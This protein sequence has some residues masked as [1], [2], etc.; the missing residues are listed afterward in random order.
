MSIPASNHALA[1]S[2][3]SA[4]E[5]MQN[6]SR[7]DNNKSRWVKD[8]F[9]QHFQVQGR[10]SLVTEAKQAGNRISEQFRHLDPHVVFVCLDNDSRE[11]IL[12][13]AGGAW[14]PNL[15]TLLLL[16]KNLQATDLLHGSVSPVLLFYQAAFAGVTATQV[17]TTPPPSSASGTSAPALTSAA[18][19]APSSGSSNPTSGPPS[20]DW[21]AAMSASPCGLVGQEQPMRQA[22]AALRAG[23]HVILLGPPGTGKTELARCICRTLGMQYDLS[24]ATSE[25]TTFDTIGGYFAVPGSSGASLD[26]MPGIVTSAI[27]KNRWLVIDE[28]NRADIDKALGELFTVLAGA[29]VTL[30]YKK[31]VQSGAHQVFIGFDDGSD[32]PDECFPFLIKTDWRVLGTMNTFDKASLYQ[33]SFAFMRRFA[34]IYVDAPKQAEFESLVR[35]AAADVD[36]ALIAK[37]EPMKASDLLVG[38]FAP[39]T[40]SG[41]D[42]LGLR[43]GPAIFFDVLSYLRARSGSW[44]NALQLPA[45]LEE[46]LSMYVYPQFEGREHEHEQIVE[47]VAPVL[48]ADAEMKADISRKLSDWTGFRKVPG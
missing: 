43:I 31:I 21:D 16:D 45:M 37:G 27:E 6:A 28:L 14:Y 26:F 2:F 7:Q 23:K 8:W 17:A 29:P 13:K 1:P 39:P 40:G 10:A 35:A 15:Q 4:V 18:P 36:A 30:P 25:W 22:I 48:Q 12:K 41:L 42:G 46:A 20:I 32:P 33:L 3:I 11:A 44:S 19:P 34:F 47:T 24:T 38:V 5:S 9:M